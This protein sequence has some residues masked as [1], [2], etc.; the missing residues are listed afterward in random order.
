[1]KSQLTPFHRG[2]YGYK[3]VVMF[4]K[5]I[6]Y[7]YMNRNPKNFV[8]RLDRMILSS[9]GEIKTNEDTRK[10]CGRI[11]KDDVGEEEIFLSPLRVPG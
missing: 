9:L 3:S 6:V 10:L 4:S 7:A 5:C 8:G 2:N 1:M 11:V